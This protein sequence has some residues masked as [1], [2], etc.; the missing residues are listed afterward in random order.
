MSHKVTSNNIPVRGCCSVAK[1]CLTLC[2][3]MNCS[4]EASLSFTISWSLCKNSCLLSQW[5]YPTISSSAAPFSSCLQSFPT[6]ASFPMSQFFASGGQSIGSIASASVLPMNIQGWLPLG[7]TGL[8]SLLSKGLSIW[9]FS[10]ATVQKHQFFGTQPSL[11]YK[12]N[13]SLFSHPYM[14]TGKTVV[15]TIRTF[16]SKVM[17]L[18]FN[19]L[20]RFVSFSS[21]EQASFHFVA[22]VTVCSG[23]G[24]QEDKICHCFPFFPIYLPWSDGTRY[25]DLSFL[26]VEF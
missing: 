10:S 1:S 14:T 9:V 22:A 13:Q 3:S 25:H 8:I 5:C 18:L 6:S 4:T 11:R 16:I 7:L 21:K 12:K 20:S 2:N 15:L 24:A 26:N 23:F 17:S 19:T